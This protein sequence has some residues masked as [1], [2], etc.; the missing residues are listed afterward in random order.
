MGEASRGETFTATAQTAVGLMQEPTVV[1]LLQG[2]A[3]VLPEVVACQQISLP[4]VVS[5]AQRPGPPL[6]RNMANGKPLPSRCFNPMED[7]APSGTVESI[8]KQ[9]TACVAGLLDLPTDGAQCKIL[10]I[11]YLSISGQRHLDSEMQTGGFWGFIIHSKRDVLLAG[12]NPDLAREAFLRVANVRGASSLV[13]EA[14]QVAPLIQRGVQ[15]EAATRTEVYTTGFGYSCGQ[16]ADLGT[17]PS[18]EFLARAI[19]RGGP[20]SVHFRNRH[21]GA[22]SL[23]SSRAGLR[24]EL[25]KAAAK[26]S[27]DFADW[28]SK[29]RPRVSEAFRVDCEWV[30]APFTLVNSLPLASDADRIRLATWETTLRGVEEHL[31]LSIFGSLP[32]VTWARI[33]AK[34]FER[35]EAIMG[36]F[37]VDNY[38]QWAVAPWRHAHG[39]GPGNLGCPWKGCASR[40][41][42]KGATGNARYKPCHDDDNGVISLSCWTN[43]VEPDTATELVF[44]INGFDV[45]LAAS[46]LRWVLFMGYIPHESR[47]AESR[48]APPTTCLDQRKG[49]SQRVFH[50][51]F[52]K[53]EAEHLATLL[54]NLPREEGSGDWSMDKVHRLCREAFA[55]DCMKPILRTGA[56][57]ALEHAQACGPVP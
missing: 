55:E 24:K 41:L 3:T 1:G 37:D 26:T 4:Q 47:P 9:I 29:G 21:L 12:L 8:I 5:L 57:D 19:A 23:G 7:S 38:R 32:N 43:V 53:P 45:V 2:P 17:R 50:S 31:M 10:Q 51:A 30:R 22:P 49:S 56:E 33:L 25:V 36:Q 54:S 15:S 35:A 42:P 18:K 20:A 27:R 34:V 14:S 39:V 40:L 6:P 44:L 16:M 11:D 46:A 52:V 28:D 13:A 48:S